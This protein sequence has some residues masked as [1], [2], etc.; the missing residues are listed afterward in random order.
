ME[1]NKAAQKKEEGVPFFPNHVLKEIMVIF[2]VLALLVTLV[3]FFPAP[4]EPQADPFSTPVHIKPEWYFLAAYQF[5]A[6]AEYLRFIGDWAPKVLGVLIL[7]VFFFVLFFL[8]FIDKKPERHPRKRS[9]AVIL[10]II[11]TIGFLMLTYWGWVR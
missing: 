8:P 4:M 9:L 11:M 10:G 3:V 7:A 1:E 2:I 5:L 6:L